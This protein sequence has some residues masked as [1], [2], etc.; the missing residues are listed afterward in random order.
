MIR[1]NDVPLAP[2]ELHFQKSPSIVNE[3]EA[4][5]AIEE[6]ER[7]LIGEFRLFSFHQVK[8]GFPPDWQADQLGKADGARESVD[9]ESQSDLPRRGDGDGGPIGQ[10][11]E[12]RLKAEKLRAE[13]LSHWSQISDS[14]RKDIKGVWEL[15]RFPWAFALARAYSATQ[16][17][18]YQDAFWKLF[19]DWCDRNPPNTGA[20]WMCGQESTFRLMAV[21]F[22]VEAMGLRKEEEERLTRFVI[23]T[24]H[25]VAA[26]LDYALSQKNNH[27]ISECVGLVTAALVLRDQPQADRWRRLGLSKLQAQCSELIYP[28]GSFSQHSL[29]YHRVLLHDLGWV[30][31]RLR[32]A[33]QKVPEWLQ[34]AARRALDFLIAITDPETGEAPLFGSNDGANIL[35]LAEA[36]Y[37]DMRPTIQM[38]SAVFGAKLPLPVGPWDEAAEWMAGSIT[39]MK[40]VNWP[41]KPP[42]WHAEVGGYAQLTAKRD[43]LFLRC[44][45]RFRHRPAQADM[46]HV[47]IWLDGQALVEDGG[48]FSYNSTERFKDLS[49]ARYHN[50]LTIDGL[51]PM[52]KMSRFLYLP[53][54]RGTVEEVELGHSELRVANDG[55]AA[56]GVI[57]QRSVSRRPAGGFVVRDSVTGAR[58]RRLTWHWRLSGE[59]WEVSESEGQSISSDRAKIRWHGVEDAK[60]LLVTADEKTALGWRSTHYAAVTPV[61]ALL[62]DIVVQDRV[63]LIT[64]FVPISSEISSQEPDAKN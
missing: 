20:N 11:K 64:E 19:S 33:Q 23:A 53:W 16:D 47:D 38:A 21:L 60:V 42:L 45:Q 59:S 5:T 50:G 39:E 12:Q 46:M 15:S 55:Y 1:W 24:G 43:R 25:R 62:I 52:K 27:G 54:P 56:L 37:L 22:A 29:I 63:E 13:K 17:P 9:G 2:L 14:G 8:A 28:D 6:A 41:V 57:W 36:E 32:Y 26:N 48:S 40:R 30:A 34:G 7:I 35:P 3:G 44:P 31:S 58:G 61:T 10:S 51:E 4:A 49:Q 18:R